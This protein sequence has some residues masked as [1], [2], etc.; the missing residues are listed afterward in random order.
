MYTRDAD[1]INTSVSKERITTSVSTVLIFIAYTPIM[2]KVWS[3]TVIP[4]RYTTVILYLLNLLVIKFPSYSRALLKT[5]LTP[6]AGKYL[7]H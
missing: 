1:V 2:T 4:L 5:G 3:G 7:L 6:M